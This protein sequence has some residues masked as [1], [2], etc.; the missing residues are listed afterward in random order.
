MKSKKDISTKERAEKAPLKKSRALHYLAAFLLSA[1]IL[2]TA[3][4]FLLPSLIPTE[5]IKHELETSLEHLLGA[6]VWIED[7]NVNLIRR[8]IASILWDI[9]AV[10]DLGLSGFTSAG[11]STLS[12]K[13]RR[14]IKVTAVMF[15]QFLQQVKN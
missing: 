1:V 14:F 7:I 12:R 13:I 8:D 4:L 6:P 5:E 11:K 15:T 2:I 10:G 9:K 3:L